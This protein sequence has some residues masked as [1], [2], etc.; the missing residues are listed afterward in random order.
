MTGDK[1]H[2]EKIYHIIFNELITA[3]R[4]RGFITYQEVAM[5]MD[6]P[7][8]G[9]YM[10]SEVGQIL[11]AISQEEHDRGRP[12]LSA[13]AVGSSGIPGEGFFVLA[14]DLGAEFEDTPDGKRKFWEEERVKVYEIWQ[15]EL[16]DSNP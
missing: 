13:V 8:R 11:G 7:L 14:R 6:L 3:A 16:K 12:M 1:Y 10:G 9:N 2:G 5:L 4:Y 15:R